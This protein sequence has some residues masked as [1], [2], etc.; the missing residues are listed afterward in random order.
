MS[1]E[2][3]LERLNVPIITLSSQ[4]SSPSQRNFHQLQAPKDLGLQV[5]AWIKDYRGRLSEHFDELLYQTP[6]FVLGQLATVSLQ[7]KNP[8]NMHKR[9]KPLSDPKDSLSLTNLVTFFEMNLSTDV[10]NVR[11]VQL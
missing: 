10:V 1:E 5:L 4:Q 11:G 7:R 8:K 3:P 9:G 2:A 6:Q